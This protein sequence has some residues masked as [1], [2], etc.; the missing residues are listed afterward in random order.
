TAAGRNLDHGLVGLEPPEFQAGLRMT[1]AV[2][3]L[4][5]GIPARRGD[6]RGQFGIGGK[7]RKRRH[8]DKAAKSHGQHQGARKH[9]ILPRLFCAELVRRLRRIYVFSVRSLPYRNGRRMTL[10]RL[11]RPFPAWRGWRGTDLG[12]ERL[13]AMTDGV[14]AIII[15]I[16]VLELKAPEGET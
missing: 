2:A 16:M 13:L 9:V 3:G 1:G 7:G 4:V 6:R 14:V 5:G 12:K 15:T 10:L 11:G 8:G